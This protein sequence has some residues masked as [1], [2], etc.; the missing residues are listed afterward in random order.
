MSGPRYAWGSRQTGGNW[1]ITGRSNQLSRSIHQRPIA[2]NP[3]P[4]DMIITND[5]FVRS[6]KLKGPGSDPLRRSGYKG[7]KKESGLYYQVGS[8]T[9][10]DP[11]VAWCFDVAASRHID[12]VMRQAH[13]NMRACILI[14]KE[15]HDRGCT[16]DEF[17][18][19]TSVMG[20]NGRQ[21]TI[22]APADDHMTVWMGPDTNT[23]MVGGHIF[24]IRVRNPNTGRSELRQ[25]DDPA[26]QRSIVPPGRQK[27]AEEFWLTKNAWEAAD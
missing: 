9:T 14:R 19:R 15:M 25:M 11:T 21:H 17:N 6:M 26:T 22:L 20:G 13:V 27:L 5:P 18:N 12:P 8:G 24:V 2:A 3:A 10:E 16:Y 1:R 7:Q 23:A 4:E